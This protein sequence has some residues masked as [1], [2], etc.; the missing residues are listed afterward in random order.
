MTNQ[1]ALEAEISQERADLAETLTSI[2]E[3]FKPSAMI[4]SWDKSAPE[5]AQKAVTAAKENPLAVGVIGAGIALLALGA[6]QA[7]PAAEVKATAAKAADTV[8]KSAA[9]MRETLYDQTNEL[10][11]VARA[12]IIEARLKAIDAQERIERGAVKAV[13]SSENAY[14]TN[15]LLICAGFA[16]AAGAVAM[17]LPRTETEDRTFGDHRDALVDKA[18]AILSEEMDRAMAQ[19]RDALDAAQEAMQTPAG[20]TATDVNAPKPH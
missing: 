2:A 19:G 17:S 18:E 12:R 20:T 14:Q 3:G 7:P 15:P 10:S 13:K 11:D 6:R 4:E 16:A 1:A 5:L 9:Q 8:K